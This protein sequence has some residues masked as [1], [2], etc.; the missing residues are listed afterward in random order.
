MSISAA[1]Q[2]YHDELFPDHI[3][4]LARTD[5]ELIKVFGNFAFDEVVTQLVPFIDPRS[6]NALRVVDEVA[7]PKEGT[8]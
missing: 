3:S 6:L 1:A 5:P 7:L 8:S 2:Q 4:T